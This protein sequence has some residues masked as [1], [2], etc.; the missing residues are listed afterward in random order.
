MLWAGLAMMLM[1]KVD[2][3][4]SFHAQEHDVDEVDDVRRRI[5]DARDPNAACGKGENVVG[6]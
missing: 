4:R 2:C 5:H 3:Q 6:A 1:R